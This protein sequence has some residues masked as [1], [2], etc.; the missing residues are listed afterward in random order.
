M[1]AITPINEIFRFFNKFISTGFNPHLGPHL[2]LISVNK[3]YDKYRS[4]FI[5]CFLYTRHSISHLIIKQQSIIPEMFFLQYKTCQ[6][7]DL[8]WISVDDFFDGLDPVLGPPL[9]ECFYPKRSRIIRNQNRILHSSLTNAGAAS[10]V[11][12]KREENVS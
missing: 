10:K 3:L 8:T 4:N 9:R 11:W 12:K 7:M 2:A 5:I 6:L 1:F